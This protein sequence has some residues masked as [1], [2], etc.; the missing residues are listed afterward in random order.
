V[1]DRRD[2]LPDRKNLPEI[3][4]ILPENITAI[5]SLRTGEISIEI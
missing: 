4:T 3:M 1:A 2:W 5:K